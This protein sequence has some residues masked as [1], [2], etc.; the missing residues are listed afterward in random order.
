MRITTIATR[1]C[2]GLV[3]AG[4]CAAAE[5]AEPKIEHGIRYLPF[6]NA[7]IERLLSGEIITHDLESGDNKELAI[8]V[9]VL[10]RAPIDELVEYVLDGRVYWASKSVVAVHLL[11]DHPPSDALFAE[12]G[13]TEDESDEV[14]GLLEA[15]PGS[16]FNLSTEEIA[17]LVAVARSLGSSASSEDPAT[18]EA[19]NDAYRKI[20]MQR[21]D[22]Y[23]RG[24]LTAIAP[25]ERGSERVDT[26]GELRENLGR[27]VYLKELM[28]NFYGAL[29]N[30]P[31]DTREDI[32]NRFA[33][34][35]LMAN[36][37]PV[38]VLA[39]RANQLAPGRHALD[40][41][42]EFYVG[43]SYNFMSILVG[44]V[45]VDEGTMV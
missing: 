30:Y 37:R 14:A 17:Q 29:V 6:E 4:P 10:I 2:L 19:V 45:R 20:L 7:D 35:K 18:R 13:F 38:Y 33:L 3:L 25:Y 40:I 31:G 27:F 23:R 12:V 28:P 8:T 9:A 22:A 21:Y 43:H 5:D 11:G 1:T 24:G 41:Y 34:I 15:E 32:R 39:R 16:E 36:D 42:T 44:A 26:G